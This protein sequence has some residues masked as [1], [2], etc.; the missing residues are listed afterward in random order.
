MFY[1]TLLSA[2]DSIRTLHSVYQDKILR[3]DNVVG[4]SLQMLCFR[5]WGLRGR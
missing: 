4:G 3:E 1:W 5:G 2:H